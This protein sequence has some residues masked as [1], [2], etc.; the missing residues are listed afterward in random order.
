MLRMPNDKPADGHLLV[1]ML[2]DCCWTPFNMKTQDARGARF[3]A[4]TLTR[5]TP[6]R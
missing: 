2:P 4:P 1:G 3:V 6:I 5:A